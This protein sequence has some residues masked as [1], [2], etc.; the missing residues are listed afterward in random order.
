MKIDV[1]LPSRGN[2][3]R[4]VSVLTC[5]DALASGNHEVTYH[6][7]CD[8]DDTL[9]WKMLSK[10]SLKI[11]VHVGSGELAPR[12]N[13]AAMQS[14]ADMVTCAADDTFPL[15]QHWDM[16]IEAG[17]QEGVPAFSWQEVND[18]TNH[19][20]LVF[21]RKWLEAIGCMTPEYF[22]FWFGDTWVAEVFELAFHQPMPIVSTLPWGGKRGKTK[23]MRDLEFWFKFF[24]ATRV[25]RLTQARAACF[26]FG[27]EFEYND[28]MIT[29]MVRRDME[30]LT[31]VPQYNEW[32]GADVGDPS[33]RYVT[34][35]A[36]ADQHLTTIKGDS[37]LI[38]TQ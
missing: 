1:I 16:V 20:L 30:Q 27:G 32:F 4:L 15:A 21:T 35:K 14:T 18:P 6:V 13:E 2:A 23:G 34:M 19:T 25:E 38:A 3:L 11:A 9:T 24:A 22:P 36:F 28:A 33:E 8:M 5:F 31:R 10:V 37:C 7:V 26:A 12:L 17:A 29:D